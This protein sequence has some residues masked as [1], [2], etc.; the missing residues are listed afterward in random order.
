MKIGVVLP[1][2]EDF[3]ALPVW[4]EVRDFAVAAESSGIDSL[5]VYD[6]FYYDP[7][8][9]SPIVGQHEAWTLLSAVA[10]VTDHAELGTL[11][12][13]STFRDPGLVAKMAVT[14]DDVSGGRLILGLGAGWHDPEYD[15]YGFPKD[16]RVDRFEE[17]LQVIVPL[18]DGGPVTFEGKYH[19]TS[20]ASLVPAPSR[21]IPVLIA[22]EGPRMLGLTAR[23]A[24]AWNTAWYGAPD[25]AVREAFA[26]MDAAAAEQG[27]R[28]QDV[29][30]TVGVTVRDPSFATEDSDEP[31]LEGP[32]EAIAEAFDEYEALGADHLICSLEPPTRGTL[33]LVVAARRL[34]S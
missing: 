22:C 25:D 4:S 14:L 30:K 26:A 27:R 15:A 24:D 33:E 34:H 16:H 29:D 28:S 20:E 31:A 13:C 6:H 19:R 11:V 2:T 8:D 32:V 9:G 7:E 12:L 21:R 17:A 1:G 3:G 5:W 18:L 10:A 23:Y